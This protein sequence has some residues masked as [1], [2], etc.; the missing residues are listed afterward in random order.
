MKIDNSSLVSYYSEENSN[1]VF[2]ELSS[3]SKIDLEAAIGIVARRLDFT[4]NKKHY[5]I[6]DVSKARSISPAAR[7]FFQRPEGGL[8][9]ILGAAFIASNPVSVLIANIF[10]KAPKNFPAKFFSNKEDAFEWIYEYRKKQL[11]ASSDFNL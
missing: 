8:K 3:G 4:T 2:A 10:I 6:A 9:N 7:E 1:I 11:A 5:L